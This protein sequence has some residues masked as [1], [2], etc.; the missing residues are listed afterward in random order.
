MSTKRKSIC[1]S[2]GQDSDKE[3]SCSKFNSPKL[4]ARKFREFICI[5]GNNSAIIAFPL[6]EVIEKQ[7]S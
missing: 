4:K 5:K 6:S 3:E 1:S 2:L 7:V